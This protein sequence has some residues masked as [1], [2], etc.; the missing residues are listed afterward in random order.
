MVKPDCKHSI[1]NILSWITATAK[2]LLKRALSSE[3][4]VQYK[5]STPT[6]VSVLRKT[7]VNSLSTLK[8]RSF[9]LDMPIIIGLEGRGR[10]VAKSLKPACTMQ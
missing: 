9:E 8:N 4:F 7:L 6:K 3:M 10:T 2:N 1:P 5:V